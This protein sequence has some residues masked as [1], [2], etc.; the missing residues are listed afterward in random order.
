[1]HTIDDKVIFTEI[2]GKLAGMC[3]E[4]VMLRYWPQPV[5]WVMPK[6]LHFRVGK[7]AGEAL[8]PHPDMP[9]FKL[10]IH[11]YLEGVWPTKPLCEVQVLDGPVEGDICEAR[12]N[13][14]HPCSLWAYARDG[15]YEGFLV[16][17]VAVADALARIRQL[18]FF[19]Q[20]H[21]LLS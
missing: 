10:P 13:A 18:S 20:A 11:R 7:L 14:S 2:E 4:L 16:G 19:E 6:N 5:G 15:F 9:T 17:N 3:G 12:S 1:M 8:V 21:H